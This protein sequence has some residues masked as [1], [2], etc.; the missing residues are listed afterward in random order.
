MNQPHLTKSVSSQHIAVTSKRV[1]WIVQ[2]IPYF[3]YINLKKVAYSFDKFL[4]SNHVL[5]VCF[6]SKIPQ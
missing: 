6:L 2:R 3:L 1:F 4:S 5:Q